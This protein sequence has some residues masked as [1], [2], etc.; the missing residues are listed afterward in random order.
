LD[1][2]KV[3]ERPGQPVDLIDNYDIDLAR[4]DVGGQLLQSR[5]LPQ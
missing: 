1:L 5:P 4:L 2:G 3:G